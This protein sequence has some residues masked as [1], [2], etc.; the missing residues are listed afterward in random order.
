MSN[1]YRVAIITDEKKIEITEKELKLPE[2]SQV[3]IKVDSCAICTLEQRIFN[4]VMKRYPFAGGHE[5]SGT[6]VAV[7]SKVKSL[8]AGDKVAARLLTSC[9]ECY[10]CRSGHE[11]QCVISFI[12][13]IH[14]GVGGP[15]GFSEYM[16]IDAKA[17]YKMADDLDLTYA[18]LSEPLA[19]CVHSINNA[20][21][22]LG[23]DVVVIGVGIMGAFHIQL[24]KLKG[25]RVIACEV[26]EDRLEIAR[27]MGADILINSKEVNAADKVKE[28]TDGRGADVVFCTAA[29][30]QLA[31]DSIQMTGKTGRVIM[32]SSFHPNKPVELNVNNVHSTEM[33]ITGAVNANTRDFLAATRLLSYKMIDPS[34]LVSD[35]VPLENIEYAFEQA[36]DPKTYRIIVK[37]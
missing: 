10:Y 15:G 20:D 1:T 14:E 22:E 4:G 30:P 36:I 8:K 33:N 9:G 26:D 31:A 23:D 34:L 12:A 5:A 35:I 6:V 29:I 24:A 27:K 25:A 11:N 19:C 13:N 32:Y 16:M 7:G 17:L 21:I 37:M 3:L 2:G 28:F 18:A